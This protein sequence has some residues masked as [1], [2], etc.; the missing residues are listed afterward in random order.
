MTELKPCPFCGGE[1]RINDM[2]NYWVILRTSRSS[3]VCRIFMESD[4]FHDKDGKQ[5]QKEKLIEKWNNRPSPWHTGKPTEEGLSAVYYLNDNNPTGEEYETL[6][7]VFVY[8]VFNDGCVD[9][10]V[11]DDRDLV[12]DADEIV[13]WQKIEPYKED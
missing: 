11:N 5:R 1:V 2:G 6:C 12:F 13:R 9:R 4:Q 10:W 3:C 7:D 8:P